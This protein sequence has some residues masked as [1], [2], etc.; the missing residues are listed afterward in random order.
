MDIFKPCVGDLIC[1][2]LVRGLI[3]EFIEYTDLASAL[4]VAV[5]FR[6]IVTQIKAA[7]K[8][9]KIYRRRVLEVPSQ[10]L[11]FLSSK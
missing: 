3:R 7:N 2:K 9:E 8:K 4:D 1:E 11:H 10:V 5:A 6:S